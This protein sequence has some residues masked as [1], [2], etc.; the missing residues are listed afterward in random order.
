MIASVAALLLAVQPLQDAPAAGPEVSQVA[1]VLDRLNVASTAADGPTYFDL[2]TPDARFIGTD[3]TEHWTLPQFR[4]FAEPYFARGRG[5]SYPAT[6]RTITIAPIECRCIAWFEE[7]LTNTSYGE[8]RGSGVLRL[9]DDGWKIEQYVLSFAIPNDKSD[10]VVA[11]VRGTD[12]P[13]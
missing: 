11:A 12:A 7:K 2:F 5:W 13:R 10:A 8:T 6:D 9:T 1:A 4:A 3:A